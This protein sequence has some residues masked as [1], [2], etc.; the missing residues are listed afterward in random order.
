MCVCACVCVYVCFS[1][2]EE[3]GRDFPCL[4]TTVHH[5]F[6][7][8]FPFLSTRWLDP[9]SREIGEEGRV[10]VDETS[11]RLS[12]SNAQPGDTGNYTCQA[13]NMA[14]TRNAH[15]WI[16]VSGEY[17]KHTQNILKAC[18]FMCVCVC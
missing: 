5:M 3:E 13:S 18:V 2:L 7:T 14:G 8:W 15:V 17:S 16:V 1:R 6:L 9:L 12:L 4:Q 10:R 11:I